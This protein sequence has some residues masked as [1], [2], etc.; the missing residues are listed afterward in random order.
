MITTEIYNGQGPGDQLWV[1]LTTRY[2][3]H[4]KEYEFGIGHPERW[5]LKNLN[6]N[7]G[8]PVTGGSNVQEGGPPITLPDT[9]INYYKEKHTYHPNFADCNISDVDKDVFNIEDNTKIEGLLHY[10]YLIDNNKDLFK[11]WLDFNRIIDNNPVIPGKII[12]NIRGG[13]YK[14]VPDLILPKNYWDM[15]LDYTNATEVEIITD[16][17]SY[18][19]SLIPNGTIFQGSMTEQ[20]E[21]LFTAEKLILSNSAFGFFPG[22]LGNAL[23]VIA[24]KYWSRWNISD[25]FWAMEMDK[26]SRFSYLDKQGRRWNMHDGYWN[27]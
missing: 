25:G 7:F 21:R 27:T 9:I 5:K 17:P 14:N 3:A 4:I 6:I 11:K 18:A 13:E 20:F 19:L 2:I 22:A 15:C 23:E 26:C 8:N 12:A 24:P 16:D 1:Y 10:S